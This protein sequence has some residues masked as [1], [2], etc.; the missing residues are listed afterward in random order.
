[1]EL[2]EYCPDM[3]KIR[4]PRCKWDHRKEAEDLPWSDDCEEEFTCNNCGEVFTC[5]PSITV[6]WTTS[7]EV[8]DF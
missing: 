4:C 7:A 1:M 8:D 6:N 5:R 2:E 3:D